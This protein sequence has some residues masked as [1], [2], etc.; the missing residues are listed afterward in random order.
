MKV[1]WTEDVPNP[2]HEALSTEIQELVAQPGHRAITYRQPRTIEETQMRNNWGKLQTR[3]EAMSSTNEVVMSGEV[4][5]TVPYKDY[6]AFLVLLPDDTFI[7]VGCSKCKY[8]QEKGCEV[9]HSNK[10]KPD[11]KVGDNSKTDG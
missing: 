8:I 3:L 7:R 11:V 9:V 10:A 2:E 5:A 1:S 6:L 4:I